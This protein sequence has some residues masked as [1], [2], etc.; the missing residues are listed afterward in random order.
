MINSGQLVNGLWMGA[1]L[2][3][4]GLAPDILQKAADAISTFPTAALLRIHTS[5]RFR[6][7]IHPVAIRAPRWLALLGIAIILLGTLAYIA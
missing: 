7:M 2:I 4:F 5:S 3:L 6:S 1:I